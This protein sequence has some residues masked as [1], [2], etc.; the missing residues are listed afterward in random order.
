MRE[1]ID[2]FFIFVGVMGLSS[3]MTGSR[4]SSPPFQRAYKL[5]KFKAED[6]LSE[7]AYK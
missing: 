7:G 2:D 5:K 3:G 1:T 4:P 6:F